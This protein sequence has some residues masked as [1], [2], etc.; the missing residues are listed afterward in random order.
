MAHSDYEMYLDSDVEA[1][2][3]Q[4]THSEHSD[5]LLVSQDLLAQPPEC[6][7]WIETSRE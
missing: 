3:P 4:T 1:L 7:E 6:G 2:L 5:H